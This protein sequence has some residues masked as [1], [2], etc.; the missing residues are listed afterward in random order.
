MHWILVCNA[1]LGDVKRIITAHETFRNIMTIRST[2]FIESQKL[3]D[4][5]RK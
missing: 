5:V 1:S 3:R 2:R 4:E